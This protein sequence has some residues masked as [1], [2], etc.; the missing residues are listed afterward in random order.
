MNKNELE[1]RVEELEL[2]LGSIKSELISGKQ[3][4]QAL[5]ESELKLNYFFNQ[6]TAGAFFMML[7]EPIFWNDSVDKKKVLDCVFEHHRITKVNQAMLEQYKT[8]EKDF[9]GMTPKDFFAHDLEYGQ[10]IWTE[11]FD[12][13]KLHIDTDERR[14]DGSQ[15][16][17]F[18]DYTCMYDSQGRVTGHFGLQID[19]TERKK[20]EDALLESEEKFRLMIKNSN[21]MIVL[22]N[23]SGEQVFVSDAVQRVTGYSSEETKGL[24]SN[25][26]HP[27]DLDNLMQRWN[28]VVTK[29]NTIVNAQYRHK[30]KENGYI[31]LEAVA[32]NFL[33]H[34]CIKAVIVNVRDISHNKKSEFLLKG[35]EKKLLQLNA[36]K[37]LFIQILGHD[38]KS[39]FNNIL[40]I[41]ELLTKNIRNYDIDKIEN[42]V[43]GINISARNAHNLLDD[44]LQWATAQQGSIVFKPQNLGLNDVCTDV[45][46]TLKPSAD[47]KNITIYDSSL[48]HLNVY[49]DADMLKTV[50][51][52]LVSN[53]IKFTND[54]GSI[55]I[56][57]EHN[58]ENVTISVSDNGIGIEKEDLSKLF[59]ISEVLTTKGTTGETGTGLGLLLC[60]EFVEKHGGIIWVES[61][62]GKGSEFSFTLPC[63]LRQ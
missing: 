26:I 51:R 43:N 7:D 37:D 33:D 38:L 39:P 18:G 19:I 24:F 25:F 13:G 47:G 57:A 6:A 14:F 30:R 61:E 36:D 1:Y 52:N 59:N 10:G 44:L 16:W 35:N 41:S 15:M 50:L 42:F 62:V 34:P 5:K 3:A 49:A 11:L 40:G 54:N 55:K 23:E 17:V 9:L 46:K 45:L 29:K 31:W 20:A 32:Q 63:N 60:K 58:L 56:N 12:K 53:A 27:D 4:E 22:I 28:E 21:D 48:D 8:T 2:E